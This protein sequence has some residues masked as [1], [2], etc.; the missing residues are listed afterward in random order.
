[1]LRVES[2]MIVTEDNQQDFFQSKSGVEYEQQL[3]A[4]P[5]ANPLYTSVQ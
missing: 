5:C 3:R 2:M 1:M 4:N